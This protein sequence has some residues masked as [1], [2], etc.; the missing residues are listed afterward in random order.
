MYSQ[1]VHVQ[2][3]AG[4]KPTD[5][6]PSSKPVSIFNKEK[7]GSRL[8]GTQ[9]FSTNLKPA[10]FSGNTVKPDKQTDRILNLYSNTSSVSDTA[11]CTGPRQELR[12]EN[13]EATH[14]VGQSGFQQT[15]VRDV[16]N[17]RPLFSTGGIIF[18]YLFLSFMR[19][20][21]IF[22]VCDNNLFIT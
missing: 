12:N 1:S 11:E 2:L 10:L 19:I 9:E 18:R 6:L 4:K 20:Q 14:R 16:A 17:R 15:A 22:I 7:D 21:S 3:L 5:K 13:Y 8:T